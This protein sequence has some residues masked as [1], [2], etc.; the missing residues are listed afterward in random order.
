MK[1]NTKPLFLRIAGMGILLL[2]VLFVAVGTLG[3]VMEMRMPGVASYLYKILMFFVT[4]LVVSASLRS[5]KQLDRKAP[6]WEK[7]L[8]GLLL[9]LGAGMLT[10]LFS[11]AFSA[12]G[13]PS[14]LLAFS[15]GWRD[16]LFFAAL[17]VLYS[18]ASGF[19]GRS[20]LKPS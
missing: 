15:F 12:W 3:N 5:L 10:T 2:A 17:A 7:L 14:S 20:P 18:S 13:D 9:G 19:R 6:W 11:L 8:L 16:T 4:W 1:N